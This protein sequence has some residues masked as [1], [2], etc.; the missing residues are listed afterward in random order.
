MPTGGVSTGNL[1]ACLKLNTVAAVGGTW[2][3]KKDDPTAG[4]EDDVRQRCKTALEIVA[5]ARG[6][7]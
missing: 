6:P 4:K 3:A 2:I 7:R 1:E 5:G